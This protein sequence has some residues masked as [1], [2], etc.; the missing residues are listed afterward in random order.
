[1]FQERSVCPKAFFCTGLVRLS[2]FTEFPVHMLEYLQSRETPRFTQ[3]LRTTL[4]GEEPFDLAAAE[5]LRAS[6]HVRSPTNS[7]DEDNGFSFDALFPLAGKMA[8]TEKKQLQ[9]TFKEFLGLVAETADAATHSAPA[10]TM[11]KMLTSDRTADTGI[12]LTTVS[13]FVLLFYVILTIY[14]RAQLPFSKCCK[15]PSAMFALQLRNACR[16]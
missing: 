9:A 8:Y 15:I 13:V 7:I 16:V 11:Y 12:T 4:C 6:S 10:A 5:A 3:R 1:M 2:A 14:C